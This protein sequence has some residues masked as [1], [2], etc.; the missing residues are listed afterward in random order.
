MSP[1]PVLMIGESILQIVIS[2]G[3]MRD[4]SVGK[5]RSASTAWNGALCTGFLVA[6]AMLY[7][8]NVTEPHH[9]HGHAFFRS[10]R[11]MALYLL[12]LPPKAMS[13]LFAGVGIKLVF[14][15]PDAPLGSD[16]LQ[17]TQKLEFSASLATCFLLQLIRQPL[18][19]VGFFRYYS[20]SNLRANRVLAVTVVLR[21]LLLAGMIAASWADYDAA[22]HF[23][24]V[25]ACFSLAFCSMHQAEVKVMEKKKP[26]PHRQKSGRLAAVRRGSVALAARLGLH[27]G[28][29]APAAGDGAK[30][31]SRRERGG[32]KASCM[33][34]VHSPSFVRHVKAFVDRRSTRHSLESSGMHDGKQHTGVM[35]EQ[36][37]PEEATAPQVPVTVASAQA[38]GASPSVAQASPP[39]AAA[40]SNSQVRVLS[41]LEA[42]QEQA[43]ALTRDARAAHPSPAP[44]HA[45]LAGR[46]SEDFI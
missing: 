40:R 44:A 31:K 9:A 15:Q 22:W 14:I 46:G 1:L 13:I 12:L 43:N 26:D 38:A 25:Q 6:L 8:F 11:P 19:S 35:P 5:V 32:K 33:C 20:I 36:T 41:P 21:L 18:H 29:H 24:L 7:S 17:M 28:A 37:A 30:T 45:P 42:L 34:Q 2:D 27:H 3:E 39:G 16:L 4:S 23:M 10:S